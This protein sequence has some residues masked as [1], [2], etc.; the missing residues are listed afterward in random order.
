MVGM[1]AAFGAAFGLLVGASAASAATFTVNSVDDDPDQVPGDGVCTTGQ[2]IVVSTSPLLFAA[3]CTLRAA[4][5]ESNSLAG[6]D[7]VEFGGGLPQIA[8]IVEI[9]PASALPWLTDE[10]VIDGYSHPEYDESNPDE[11]PEI[12][13][14]GSNAGATANGIVFGP[15]ASGSTIRGM[16]VSGFAQAGI[17]ISPFFGPAPTNIVIEGNHVGVWRGVFYTSGNGTDGIAING[18]SGNRIGEHCLPITG[19]FGRR[20]LIS[21]N[22]RH[23]IRITGVSTDNRIGGNY[24]GTDRFGNATSVPFGGS[25]PNAEYGVHVGAESTGNRIGVFAVWSPFGPPLSTWT[26][27]NVISGNGAGGVFVDGDQNQVHANRI[28]TN[29]AGT[30]ALPNQGPGVLVRGDENVVGR[31]GLARNVIS[32][33]VGS[34]VVIP[35]GIL[36]AP[37][38]LNEIVGNYIGVNAT[39]DGVLGNAGDGVSLGGEANDVRENVIGGNARGVAHAGLSCNVERNYI[40]TNAA[41]DDLGNVDAGVASFGIG[42]RIGGPGVGNTIGFNDRGIDA[43]NAAVTVQGNYVGTTAAGHDIGNA[44]NGISMRAND[45]LVGG[46]EGLQNGLGNVVGFNGGH[47]IYVSG[48]SATVTG[49]YVGT[50][51]QD[52]VP[53]ERRAWDFRRRRRH[54]VR[55]GFR[56]RRQRRVGARVRVRPGQP[57]RS[58]RGRGDRRRRYAGGLPARQPAAL[59]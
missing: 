3:E 48:R 45:Y 55:D 59:E 42:L 36:P 19:C 15:G 9:V 18:S 11:T 14:R 32:G 49:N 30:S 26:A 53:A 23:G 44:G 34:G 31:P 7:A 13:L 4:M 5:M 57:R 8:G 54:G 58:Q 12:E 50:D 35:F 25:T 21:A 17:S 29:V 27:G 51:P 20:N 52:R 41:N 1:G 16:A 28:G 10:I 2:F 24:I 33:N 43:H 37:P 6:A 47:G 56:D 22:G 39:G 40:G 46:Y 38:I